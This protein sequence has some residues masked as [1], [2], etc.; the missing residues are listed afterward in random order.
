[1][2]TLKA[3]S[4]FSRGGSALILFR[5]DGNKEIGTGHVMRCLSIADA[6]NES[7]VKAAFVTA[8]NNLKDLIE[9][10]G[11]QCHVLHT[12]F[13]DMKSELSILKRQTFFAAAD[14]IVVDS[15]HADDDYLLSLTREKKTVY[16]DDYP[17]KRPVDVIVNYNIYA[18]RDEY[19]KI[20]DGSRTL[21]LLGP[22]YAP[23]RREFRDIKPIVIKE[24]AKDIL[25]LAGG[26]DPAHAALGFAKELT[27]HEDGLHYIIVTGAMSDDNSRIN[28]IAGRSGG[29]IEVRSNVKDMKGLMCSADLAV[30]A[31]GSTLY[32]L[33]A[34]GVPTLC[35]I[36]ADNQRLV[37]EGFKDKGAMIFAGDLREKESFYADLY[38]EIISLSS[39]LN[40]RQACGKKAAE[41][42][43]GN[44]AVRLVKKLK[45]V[46][47][48]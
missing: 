47:F 12:D 37:A 16:I 7:G 46:V 20:M 48:A 22:E 44:G 24:W 5:A 23:L 9:E 38:R 43:D 42:V 3:Y 4:L 41:L 2:R 34:C 18:D 14:A 27:G 1:M 6:F 25:F 8:D 45:E 26:S 19:A 31:A 28:A 30:S 13:K 10:R 11:Y 40:I 17:V 32:E 15:Y 36:L 29:R 33:C 35:Y 21:L 39:D